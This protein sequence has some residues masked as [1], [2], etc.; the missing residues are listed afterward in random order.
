MPTLEKLKSMPAH[1][2]FATGILIDIDDDLF[3]GRSGKEL[4]WVAIRG[5]INDWCIYI[6]F[7]DKSIEWIR[8]YGNKIYNEEN[9]KKCVECDKEAF[10]RYRY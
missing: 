4:K 9:I 8:D 7:V 10:K 3:M 5:E 6:H 2:I 1:T